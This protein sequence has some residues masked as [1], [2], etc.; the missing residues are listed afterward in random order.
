MN[1]FEEYIVDLLQHNIVY[2][3]NEVQVRRQFNDIAQLP[4]I[5]LSVASIDTHKVYGEYNTAEETIYERQATIDINLWCNT[6]EERENISA[7]IMDC[8]YRERVAYYT[9]CSQYDDGLCAFDNLECPCVHG[10]DAR[11]IRGQCPEPKTRGYEALWKKHD[12][13]D[14]T[15]NI[16][17]PMMMDELNEHPPLL[18]NLFRCTASYYDYYTTDGLLVEDVVE[19]IRI[20]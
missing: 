15:I 13:I 11:T 10:T 20:V 6:E 5:T 7:Q 2:N 19:D 18:R 9:Y 1:K 3:T 16:E 4:T 12:L 17:P 14:G 8:F